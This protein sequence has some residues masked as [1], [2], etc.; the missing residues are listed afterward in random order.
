MTESRIVAA[1]AALLCIIYFRFAMP[2][3]YDSCL[4]ALKDALGA[5][6]ISLPVS[7]EIAA[8]LTWD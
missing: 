4:P 5:E 3:L 2:R 7:G 1:A 8:W 6:Q